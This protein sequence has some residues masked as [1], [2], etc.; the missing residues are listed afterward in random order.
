MKLLLLL[1]G[2][3]ML[4]CFLFKAFLVLNSLLPILETFSLRVLTRYIRDVQCWFL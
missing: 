3:T 2:S 1:L 4:H